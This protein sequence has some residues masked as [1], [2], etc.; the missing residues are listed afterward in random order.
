MLYVY[1]QSVLPLSPWNMMRVGGENNI[2]PAVKRK[3]L[4]LS[5][6]D[7]SH[8]E[9]AWHY[10]FEFD[11]RDSLQKSGLAQ[12]MERSNGNGSS[13]FKDTANWAEWLGESGWQIIDE[14]V[15]SEILNLKPSQPT[16]GI[17]TGVRELPVWLQQ[18]ALAVL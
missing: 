10:I 2:A 9:G 3:Y 11:C 15:R 18:P 6:I 17:I 5:N 13:R 7:A 14:H 16:D 4:L 1:K 8:R 12:M